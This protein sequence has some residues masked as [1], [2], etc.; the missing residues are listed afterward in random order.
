MPLQNIAELCGSLL[1]LSSF[2]AA[3]TGRLN[4]T[5]TTYRALNLAG[6]SILAIVALEQHSWGFLLLEG[7]WAAVSAAAL[8]SAV[9]GRGQISPLAAFPRRPSA[10]RQVG[11]E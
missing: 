5:S 3:Q 8:I 1:I 2:L 7:V 4:Q 10:P 11:K 9:R 6:S